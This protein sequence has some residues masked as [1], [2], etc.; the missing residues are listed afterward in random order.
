[1]S[2]GEKP[3]QQPPER[4]H[5]R[6][7]PIY[8]L[9][10]AL[11]AALDQDF[12]VLL[13][14]KSHPIEGMRE[15]MMVGR[16]VAQSVAPELTDEEIAA[17]LIQGNRVPGVMEPDEDLFGSDDPD[18]KDIIAARTIYVLRELGA[19]PRLDYDPEV[20]EFTRGSEQQHLVNLMREDEA[21]VVRN[22]VRRGEKEY[23]E[24]SRKTSIPGIVVT[25]G[26]EKESFGIPSRINITESGKPRVDYFQIIVRPEA[27]AQTFPTQ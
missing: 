15:S 20:F 6:V 1:M 13:G 4:E 16:A 9:N 17:A 2:L 23:V 22:E 14:G 21:D 12:Y 24:F 18:E 5:G 8:T 3:G 7:G 26:F 19:I 11:I 25:V 27:Y 10:D